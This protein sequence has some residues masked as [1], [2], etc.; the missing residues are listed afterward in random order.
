MF[1]WRSSWIYLPA[2]PWVMPS[3]ATIDTVLCLE[4][5]H[6]AIENRQPPEGIIHHSDRGVQ[7][8]S[9]D[10]VEMLSQT[11]LS[12][13]VCLVREIPTTMPPPKVFLKLLKSKKYIS[14]NTGPWKMSRFGFPFSSKKCTIANVCIPLSDTDRLWN[15]KNCFSTTRT[16]VRLP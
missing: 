5:L 3:L 8:A 16:L 14:G 13:S 6:M 2:G 11:R 4:A 15:L 10:Y 1:I 9:H 12:A 7:Y